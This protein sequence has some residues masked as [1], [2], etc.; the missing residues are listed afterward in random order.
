MSRDLCQELAARVH[1]YSPEDLDERTVAAARTAIID[2]VGV[3]LLGSV[4]ESARIAM[5]LP[6]MCE[7]DGPAAVLGTAI[8]TSAL[9]ATMVNGV[10]SHALDFDDFTEDFGGHP[11]V[12]VLPALVALG[13]ARG[14]TWD[15]LLAAYVA[16]VELET[17]LAHAV[18]FHHYQKGWHP[19]STLGVFGCAAA[20]AHLMALD[21]ERT[22]TALAIAASFASGVKGN[23]GTM[24]KPLHVG[25]STRSG[26]FAALL[27]EEGFTANQAVLEHRQGFFQVYNGQGNFDLQ[28]LLVE[29]YR[30]PLVVEP[31]LSIKQFACCGS[32]HP[33]IFMALALR[34]KHGFEAQAIRSVDIKTHPFRL[35]HTDQPVPTTP[36]EAKF[37]IQYAVARALTDGKVLLE[38]FE[39]GAFTEPE[40]RRLLDATTAG[41]DPEMSKREER[42]F[43]AEV[44]VELLDGSRWSERAEHLPGRGAANPMTHAELKEK[45]V[46][47]A[48]RAL[49]SSQVAAAWTALVEARGGQL[50]RDIFSPMGTSVGAGP[51]PVVKMAATALGED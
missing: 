46:D 32:T 5:R 9:D 34:A 39:D 28:K 3:T 33:A 27:A 18:H 51:E 36:L 8:R 12:P 24:T 7:A 31:G 17:R 22:A 16:G 37:S 50:V 21:L 35:P 1:A 29:W 47:C 23:F 30:P 11:S 15:A 40:I 20:C 38:D 45:F 13:E 41:A 49:P 48:S 43:G 4:E 2:T 6:G 42:T 44:T 14:A 10:A 25:H 19:T 26:L